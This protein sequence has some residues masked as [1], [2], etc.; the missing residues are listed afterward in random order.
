MLSAV[1]ALALL[2]SGP[3][4][5]P[6][7]YSLNLSVVNAGVETV[8]ARTVLIEDGSANVTVQDATGVFEMNAT[9]TPVQGD[10]DD[11]LVLDVSLVGGDGQPQEPRLI[12]RRG[13][14]ALI[15]I[16]QQGADG[17]MVQGLEIALIPL[18][19]E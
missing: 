13:A 19:A 18:P 1:A 4:D 9:L 11:E 2:F 14:D 15:Q 3:G 5:A 17:R 10:G 16:G 8:A 12:V 7:R 6:A